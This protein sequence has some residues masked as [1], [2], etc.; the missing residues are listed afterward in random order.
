MKTLAFWIALVVLA[1]LATPH[2]AAV[3]VERPDAW[4]E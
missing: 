3:Y 2:A 4:F 1:A